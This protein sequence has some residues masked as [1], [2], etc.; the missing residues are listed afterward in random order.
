M[1]NV[2]LC[3]GTALALPLKDASVHTCVTSP[4]YYGLRSYGI[5][6]G[7]LGLEDSPDEYIA[8]MVQVFREV[9]RVLHPMG[10]CWVN[11]G[12]S[13]RDK[14]LQGLPWRLALAMQQDGWVLRSEVIWHKVNCLPESVQDRCVRSHEQVFMFAKQA[15]YFF[16]MEGV[17]EAVQPDA[18]DAFWHT[19]RNGKSMVDHADDAERGR[20]DTKTQVDGWTRMSNPNGRACRS[21]WA[22]ASEP[23]PFAHFA[24]FPSALVRRCLLAGAPSQVCAACG[25]PWRRVVE[26]QRLLDG[27]PFAAEAFCLPTEPFRVAAN[28]IGHARYSTQTT[29]HG[30]TATCRCEAGI[31]KAVILD[32]FCGSGTTLLVARELGHHAIGLDLSYPYLHDIARERLGLAALAAWQGRNGHHAPAVTYDDLPLFGATP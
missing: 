2:L 12:D 26:R 24:T 25:A 31:G 30:F 23:T 4:P 13:M 8:A 28:G 19:A 22:I 16:D 15:R 11:I 27:Q 1:S 29:D 14:Q 9:K 32:P 17:R 3:Q 5:G 20:T 18:R 6:E 10:T 7:E 21:V